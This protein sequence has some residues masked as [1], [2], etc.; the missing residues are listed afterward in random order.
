MIGSQWVS[1]KTKNSVV[2]SQKRVG[3]SN[4]NKN[5]FI[6]YVQ[7]PSLYNDFLSISEAK[8]S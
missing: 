5:D 8:I 1:S 6:D 4:F 3:I 2:L 7:I